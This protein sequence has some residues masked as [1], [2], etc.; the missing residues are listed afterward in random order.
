ML[1]GK[2]RKCKAKISPLYPGI[3]LLTGVLFLV[4]YLLFGANLEAAKWAA[5]S[6][7]L[8]VL[9][10]TDIRERILPDA[11]NLTGFVIAILISFFLL[12]TDGAAL[13][14]SNHIFDFPPPLAVLS[15]VDALL[16]A[17]VGSGL[18]WIVGE[19][20]FRTARQGRHGPGR[21]E[22]DGHGGSVFGSE[23]H[24]THGSVRVA[25]GKRDRHCDRAY[26]AQGAGL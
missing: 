3:E 13:W 1:G 23:A 16:G 21:R 15:V 14:I 26:D 12:P 10:A 11:V 22:N 9:T 4:C 24:I 6:A 25:A 2:C 18:L 8:V 17:I 19:G 20:Y 5:L 7:L